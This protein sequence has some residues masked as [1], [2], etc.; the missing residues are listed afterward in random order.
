MKKAATCAAS[1]LGDRRAGQLGSGVLN[2][3]GI[4]RL[5]LMLLD[6]PVRA[7]ADLAAASQAGAASL[8]LVPGS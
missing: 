2:S 3:A 8:L 1:L 4:L 7:G 5:L 6:T